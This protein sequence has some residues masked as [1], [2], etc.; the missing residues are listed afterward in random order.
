MTINLNF[1]GTKKKTFQ[2]TNA[3]VCILVLM[4]ALNTCKLINRYKQMSHDVQHCKF[5]YTYK[6]VENSKMYSII[7]I[8][9]IFLFTVLVLISIPD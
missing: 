5:V 2:Q 6:S 7:N 3:F 8:F 4:N 9:V 1:K